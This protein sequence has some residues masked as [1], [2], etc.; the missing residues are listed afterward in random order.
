MTLPASIPSMI[1]CVNS[2]W[3]SF[4]LRL[5]NTIV[6]KSKSKLPAAVSRTWTRRLTT[7]RINL[8][9]SRRTQ[10]STK[11]PAVS[12]LTTSNWLKASFAQ[13]RILE[14]TS[15]RQMVKRFKQLCRSDTKRPCRICSKLLSSWLASY[16]RWSRRIRELRSSYWLNMMVLIS[17][18]QR[19]SILM[20][21]KWARRQRRNRRLRQI[22]RTL[23]TRWVRFVSSGRNVSRSNES[24]KLLK[25]SWTKRRLSN[26][27][28]LT[29]STRQLNSCRLTTVVWSHEETWSVPARVKREA[30]AERSEKQLSSSKD[31]CN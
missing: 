19:H 6:C 4:R 12:R 31:A 23:S 5:R 28:S 24:A 9:S 15:L 11:R 20:I 22:A 3:Q 2:G 18:T 16:S 17:S 26:A 10:R 25:Q 7:R 30:S 1:R 29:H 13:K 21:R 8:K 14:R 27:R